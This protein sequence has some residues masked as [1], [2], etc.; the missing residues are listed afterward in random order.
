MVIGH[1]PHWIQPIEWYKEKPIIYS[2]GNFIFDQNWSQETKEGL[3]LRLA[4]TKDH[5]SSSLHI[6]EY[7]PIIIEHGTTPRPATPIEK[8]SILEHVQL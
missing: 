5:E 4:V 7:I 6:E 1:H 3:V 8:Q 2:L